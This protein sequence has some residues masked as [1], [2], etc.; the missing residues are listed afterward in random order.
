MTNYS[1]VNNSKPKMELE[2]FSFVN[3]NL[4]IISYYICM[5]KR[6][7]QLKFMDSAATQTR[8]SFFHLD[9]CS[10]FNFDRGF[11]HFFFTKSL[12]CLNFHHSLTTLLL[13]ESPIPSHISFFTKSLHCLNF[14]HSLTTVGLEVE[15]WSSTIHLGL[16]EGRQ[17]YI[18]GAFSSPSSNQ[19]P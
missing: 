1:R 16:V 6:E 17:L 11:T 7:T 5:L 13:T 4:L 15:A 8:H 12:H 10:F 19:E 14:C 18:P 9:L 3:L 2:K